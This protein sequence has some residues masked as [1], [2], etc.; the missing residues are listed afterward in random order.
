MPRADQSVLWSLGTNWFWQLQPLRPVQW[1]DWPLQQA[2]PFAL[3]PFSETELSIDESLVSVKNCPYTI[4]SQQEHHRWGIKLWVLCDAVTNYC[5]RFYCYRG[6]TYEDNREEVNQLGQGFTVV[7]KLMQMGYYLNK[8][9][10]LHLDNFFTTKK[11]A[12]FC[13]KILHML[14]EQWG[15]NI[16]WDSYLGNSQQAKRSI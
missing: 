7:K 2:L 13:R 8:G 10:H 16:C 14:Q 3:L 12:R 15:L 11:L 6:A 1:F 5:L 4:Y 9:F